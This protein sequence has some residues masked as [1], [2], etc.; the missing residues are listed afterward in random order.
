MDG[1]WSRLAASRSVAT[2]YVAARNSPTSIGE[3]RL[4]IKH[5]T[6]GN[7]SASSRTTSFICA[8]GSAHDAQKLRSET[9]LR[10]ASRRDLKCSGE[11]TSTRLVSEAMVDVETMS[12]GAVKK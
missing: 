10:S 4:T 5:R 7:F 1:I 6:E 8:H 9:R 3:V 12:D 2:R 11:E